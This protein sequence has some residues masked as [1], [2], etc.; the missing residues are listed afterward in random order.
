AGRSLART[1]TRPFNLIEPQSQAVPAA[2]APALRDL[3]LQFDL[4]SLEK[5]NG[6]Q[7]TR[8]PQWARGQVLRLIWYTL[9]VVVYLILSLVTLQ[10]V[11]ALPKPE[12]LP[13]L[14]LVT[15]ALLI[16]LILYTAYQLLVQ[17]N[18]ID[19]ENAGV[20]ARRGGSERWRVSKPDIQ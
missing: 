4:W 13:Y 16:F 19:V 18:E 1:I 9:L 17:P 7:F 6:L 11:I 10:K 8:A 20:T 15:A 12:F 5:K 14:G 3:P 2:P